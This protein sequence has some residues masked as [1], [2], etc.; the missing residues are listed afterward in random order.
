MIDLGKKN[1]IG[2]MI[3]AVDYEGALFRIMSA[4]RDH[5][6]STKPQKKKNEIEHQKKKN[7]NS[8]YR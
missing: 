1:V 3:D 5:Q 4:A 7:P 2:V 8:T 6:Q